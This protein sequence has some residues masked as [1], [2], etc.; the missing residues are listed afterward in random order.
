MYAGF[1]WGNVRER[2]HMEGGWVCVCVCVCVRER[3]RENTKLDIQEVA[4][5][6]LLAEDKGRLSRIF[7]FHKMQGIS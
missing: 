2:E 7:R 4:W 1:G 3:E 6:G 5:T